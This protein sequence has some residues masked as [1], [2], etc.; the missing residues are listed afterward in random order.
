[1]QAVVG[2]AAES[3][4]EGSNF[5]DKK[6]AVEHVCRQESS[7]GLLYTQFTVAR[8]LLLTASDAVYK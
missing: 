5:T 7:T 2:G 1:M 4:R 8:M 6:S 3:A